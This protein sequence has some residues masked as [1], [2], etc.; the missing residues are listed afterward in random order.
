MLGDIA[1]SAPP[2]HTEFCMNLYLEAVKVRITTYYIKLFR[3]ENK[4]S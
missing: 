2:V 3:L 1:Y 4:L